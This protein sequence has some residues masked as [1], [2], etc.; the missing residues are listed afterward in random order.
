M[1]L[2]WSRPNHRD[3][4]QEDCPIEI[5]LP[6]ALIVLGLAGWGIVIYN[7]LVTASN[8]VKAG[9]SDIGVQLKRRH[10]LIPKLVSAVRA[11]ADYE[12]ATLSAV[13]ELRAQSEQSASPETIAAIEARLGLGI[14]RLL[15]IAEDYPDLKASESFLDLQ[16]ELSE[17][18]NQ[19]QFARR[20]YNGAVRGYNTQIQSFPDMLVARPFGFGSAEYFDAEL[21]SADSTVQAQ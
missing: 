6:I 20:Y 19:I 2:H 4:D 1:R 18:E 5:L 10:D 15:A 21:D 17:V 13:T 14:G 11:Y 9:W 7:R 12:R 3:T 16:N 8:H